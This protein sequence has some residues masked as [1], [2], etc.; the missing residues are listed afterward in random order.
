[1]IL[2]MSS[3]DPAREFAT[4]VVRRLKAAGHVA[5]W[6]GGCVRDLQMGREP[7]DYDVA[8][9]AR[10][11]QVRELFGRRK[12]LAVGE[13][14]GVVIALGPRAGGQHIKV[15]V[16]TFRSEGSYPDGRRPDPEQI[17]FT[18]PREDAQRRDFTINGMFFDPLAE[19]L[20]DYV[21]G[22]QDLR[23]GIVRAIGRPQDRMQEDKLRM[24]RAVRFAATLDFELDPQ[25]ASAVEEL[26]P[27]LG[28]VSV[29][30]ITQELHKMLVN[31]HRRRAVR[32]SQQLGLLSVILPELDAG[33]ADAA[34][35]S[36]VLDMLDQLESPRF[37]LALATLLQHL[38]PIGGGSK[39]D[40]DRQG[41]VAGVARRLKLSNAQA[42]RTVWLV[43]HQH[44]L[45][46]AET[47]PLSKLKRILSHEYADDLLRWM[48]ADQAARRSSSAALEFVERFLQS[49]PAEELNPLPL[50]TGADLI[51]LGLQPARRFQMLL[52][53]ARDAQLEGRIAT[54]EDAKELVRQLSESNQR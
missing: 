54:R 38:A 11:E 4:D 21:G 50:I 15:E 43:A 20:A 6:A 53:Q 33:A 32:L 39:R 3:M 17:R 18:T 16:A 49:T 48:H 22:E 25:T 24:L 51:A 5:L 40:R 26:A 30:R 9:D 31:R 13:S 37:E 10:P 1:M 8:T 7:Q 23:A 12:T 14:F 42:D 19:Q 28:V 46:E 27:E 2:D 41:T 47:L 44:D 45:A 34:A 36:H 52:E 29:E 35:W